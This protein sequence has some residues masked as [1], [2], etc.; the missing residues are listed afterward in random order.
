MRNLGL[1][2]DLI[3]QIL[4]E[5][6]QTQLICYEIFVAVI[7]SEIDVGLHVQVR[8]QIYIIAHTN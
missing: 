5:D 1:F 7:L 8:R 3:T 6:L 4:I 2:Y